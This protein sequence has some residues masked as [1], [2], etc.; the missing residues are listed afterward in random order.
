MLEILLRS[1]ERRECCIL[2]AVPEEVPEELSFKVLNGKLEK[3]YDAI[4]RE[5][6]LIND[7]CRSSIFRAKNSFATTTHFRWPL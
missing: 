1:S 3:L 7:S 6:V 4:D 5:V 2:W